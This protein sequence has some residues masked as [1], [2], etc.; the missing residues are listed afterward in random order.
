MTGDALHRLS[1]RRTLIVVLLAG[2][3]VGG[4]AQAW[5]TWRSSEAAVNAA[6]DRSL[7]GAIRAID[8][9]VSTDS[10]GVGVELPYVMFELFELTASGAVFYRVATEDGLVEIGSPDLPMPQG[11]LATR[12]PY[13]ETAMYVDGPVRI[14][15]YVRPIER[16]LTNQPGTRLVIQVAEDL[17]SR[18]SFSRQFIWSAVTRDLLLALFAAGMV[19]AAVTWSLRPLR[20]LRTEVQSR[21]PDDLSPVETARVPADVLPLVEAMNQHV[22]RY[23][24]LLAAQR[25]FLDDASHQL[26][27]PLATLLMQVTFAQR[28]P[29]AGKV[30][31]ALQAIRVQLKHTIRQAN[32]MLALARADASSDQPTAPVDL[33]ALARGVTTRWWSAAREGG[34][35]LGYEAP[36]GPL[37]VSGRA[38]LLEEAL[39][40]LLDNALRHTPAG[41]RVTVKITPGPGTVCIHVSD[42]G[43]GIPE[44]ELPRAT[45]RFF[46]A[47]NAQG[48]GSGLGLAIVQS[49]VRRHHGQLHLAR[50]PNEGGLRATLELPL[51]KG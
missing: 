1:L 46:R 49:I 40:N 8:A 6:F 18:K 50:E 35:D 9:N 13:F 51:H 28:E 24:D 21:A 12:Q 23:R 32:Q 39:S 5:M 10:G 29:D 43:P 44:D 16:P 15:T 31:E 2:V 30:R 3:F 37:L 17:S 33:A 38:E 42:N 11:P 22:F 7:Y 14:G 27:T 19:A 45:E 34:V 25:R 47:S 26:R 41:G 20:Q 36:A 48:A 4:I